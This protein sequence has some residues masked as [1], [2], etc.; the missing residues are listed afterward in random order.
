[1]GIFSKF[2]W[3]VD[4]LVDHM[5]VTKSLGKNEYELRLTDPEQVKKLLNSYQMKRLNLNES[6]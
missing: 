5:Y 2:E 6:V 4:S 1:M 3:K